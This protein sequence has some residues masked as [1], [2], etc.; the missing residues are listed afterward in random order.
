MPWR[1]AWGQ[2]QGWKLASPLAMRLLTTQFSELR[3]PHL[4]DGNEKPHLQS[5]H[6]SGGWLRGSGGVLGTERWLVPFP[7]GAQAAGSRLMF[8]SP[9]SFS[10][11]E[12]KKQKFPQRM[13]LENESRHVN[14]ALT[15][16]HPQRFSEAN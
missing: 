9:L 2:S 4:S 11:G 3:S 15:Y 16:L 10:S 8:L 5:F 1:S 7:A 14:H 13:K 6:S 12:D